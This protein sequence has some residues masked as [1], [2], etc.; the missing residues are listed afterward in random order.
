M[1]LGQGGRGEVDR[2]EDSFCFVHHLVVAEAEHLETLRSKPCIPDT[3]VLGI[4]I[5]AVEFDDEPGVVAHEVADVPPKGFL[6]AE[7][8]RNVAS[9]VIPE[10]R[11]LIGDISTELLSSSFSKR[12]SRKPRHGFKMN[13]SLS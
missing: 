11:F 12:M 2:F 7:L 5:P 6:S 4:M 9:D 1:G 8:R 10:Q 3:V 13:E